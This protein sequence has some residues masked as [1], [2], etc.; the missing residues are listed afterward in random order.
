MSLFLEQG[1]TEAMNSFILGRK[2]RKQ[3]FFKKNTVVSWMLDIYM[4][5]DKKYKNADITDVNG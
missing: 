5:N 1:R 4:Q 3:D 2:W